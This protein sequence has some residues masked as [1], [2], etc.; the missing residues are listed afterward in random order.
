MDH[1]SLFLGP[2]VAVLRSPTR[3]MIG[4]LGAMSG[5]MRRC[6]RVDGRTREV[7]CVADQRMTRD[8][9]D[10]GDPSACPC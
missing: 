1:S 5:L 4:S 6:I 10:P 3:T 2:A 9:R 7:D 8:E